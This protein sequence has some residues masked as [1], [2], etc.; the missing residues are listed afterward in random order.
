MMKFWLYPPQHILAYLVFHYP[1]EEQE[2]VLDFIAST[3][4]IHIQNIRRCS[5]QV[6]FGLD[7]KE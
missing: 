6:I 3:T 4:D 7:Y 5:V 1:Q 2:A